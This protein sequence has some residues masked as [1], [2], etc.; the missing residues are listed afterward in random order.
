MCNT[1][2]LTNQKF[3]DWSL[4]LKNRLRVCC[5]VVEKVWERMIP[6]LLRLSPESIEWFIEDQAFLR[7]YDSAPRPPHYLL[8]PVSRQQVASLSQ[9]S[10]VS[11]V[12]LTDGKGGERGWA[13]SWIKLPQ[14]SLDLYKSFITLWIVPNTCCLGGGGWSY[15]AVLLKVLELPVGEDGGVGQLAQDG[16]NIATGASIF[17]LRFLHSSQDNQIA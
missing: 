2:K 9:S 12:E 15:L 8:S 11:P 16:P 6:A 17:I 3:T 4:L 13:W 5:T 10:C 7:S 14:E 1:G